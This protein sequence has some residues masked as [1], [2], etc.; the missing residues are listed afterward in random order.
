MTSELSQLR[1]PAGLLLALFIGPVPV[2]ATPTAIHA[3]IFIDGDAGLCAPGSG[4]TNCATADGSPSKPYRIE[5]WFF[6]SQGAATDVRIQFVTKHVVLTDND[7]GGTPGGGGLA[8]I[9]I[10]LWGVDHATIEGNAFHGMDWGILAVDGSGPRVS[11]NAFTSVGVGVLADGA[12]GIV[13]DHNLF[14]GRD[15]VSIRAPD[16]QIILNQ[17]EDNSYAVDLQAEATGAL[18]ERNN[19]VRTSGFALETFTDSFIDARCNWWDS[20]WGPSLPPN[21]AAFGGRLY[22]HALWSPYLTEPDPY[23]GPNGHDP[24]LW[25]PDHAVAYLSSPCYDVVPGGP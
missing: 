3:P 21:Y 5:S 24:L 20:P 4:V 25:P 11:R 6:S 14:R 2:E 1:L 17:F 9:G 16:A 18:V 12:D 19:F 10:M 8:S 22:G 15:G 13:V 23:A 7:F